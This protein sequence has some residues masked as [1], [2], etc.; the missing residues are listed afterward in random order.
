MFLY[1][2]KINGNKLVKFLFITMIIIILIILSFGIYNIFIKKSEKKELKLKDTIKQENVYELTADNYT[3][4]LQAVCQNIDSYIGTKVHFVGYV[5]RVLDFNDEQFVLARNMIIDKN[6][7]QS[8]IVGFLCSSKDVKN[9]EDGTWVD[10]TGTI[11]KGDYYGDI[12]IIRVDKI[13]ETSKP[14]DLFVYPPDK[15]Y[16]PTNGIL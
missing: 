12:A 6:T 16:I 10:V 15:N 2:L 7:N 14:E 9:F 13:F 5:Y 8:L 3:N 4:V 11:V 1:N